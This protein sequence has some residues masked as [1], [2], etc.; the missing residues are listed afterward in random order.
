MSSLAVGTL[1]STTVRTS[2]HGLKMIWI[3]A[4]AHTADVMKHLFLVRKSGQAKAEYMSTM[5]PPASPVLTV[6]IRS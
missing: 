2:V 6:T 3:H 5:I 1:V 4:M